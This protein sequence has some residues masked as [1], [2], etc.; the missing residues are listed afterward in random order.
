M[1]RGALYFAAFECGTPT[2]YTLQALG[3]PSA[4]LTYEI[5]LRKARLEKVATAQAITLA[6][7]MLE[8]YR[9]MPYVQTTPF[10]A[11]AEN[12]YSIGLEF[13]L[14]PGHTEYS[15]TLTETTALQEIGRNPY[16][17]IEPHVWTTPNGEKQGFRY[18]AAA[19]T[20]LRQ[21]YGKEHGCPAI[22]THLTGKGEHSESLFK[23]Y[24]NRLIPRVIEEYL[25]I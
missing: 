11:M 20:M 15:Q 5:L 1:G 8:V 16:G 9:A 2:E 4:E 21:A 17:W 6:A 7:G 24:W 3:K 14:L 13:A 18:T 19:R 23:V 12:S 10:S 25:A 22:A